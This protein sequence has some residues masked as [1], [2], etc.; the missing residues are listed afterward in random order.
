MGKRGTHKK[1]RTAII[2][3]LTT[4]AVDEQQNNKETR[5]V[6]DLI[7]RSAS[8]NRAPESKS[9]FGNVWGYDVPYFGENHLIAH[10]ISI[11]L[12]N[13]PETVSNFASTRCIFMSQNGK[14][15][16]GSCIKLPLQVRAIVPPEIW[17]IELSEDIPYKSSLRYRKYY[18]RYLRYLVAHELA[19]A[20]LNHDGTDPEDKE[21][22]LV[23]ELAADQLAQQWGFR[24][25]F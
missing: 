14:M 9:L 17:L 23:N 13:V 19:H 22:E 24:Q 12:L 3:K 16:D 18:L 20:Y 8:N 25:P 1:S 4:I 6:V 5:V 11:V 10:A 2:G 21:G 15:Q 7:D